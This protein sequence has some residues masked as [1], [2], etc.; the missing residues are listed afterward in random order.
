MP[1]MLIVRGAGHVANHEVRDLPR[2]LSGD[3]EPVICEKICDCKEYLTG[4]IL[5]M[6]KSIPG[7]EE[8]P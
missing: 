4:A 5:S 2:D 7:S 8:S 3:D 1:D 6:T